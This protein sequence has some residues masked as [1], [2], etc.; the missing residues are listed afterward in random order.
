MAPI[1][2]AT[3]RFNAKTASVRNKE[4]ILKKKEAQLG[5]IRQSFNKVM[6]LALNEDTLIKDYL[7]YNRL[8]EKVNYFQLCLCVRARK[9]VSLIGVWFL[10]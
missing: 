2:E 7:E 6:R 1:K 5:L 8:E 10:H 9:A 3:K 4:H